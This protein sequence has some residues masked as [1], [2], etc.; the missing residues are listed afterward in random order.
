VLARARTYS[1][2]P[3]AE[4][5]APAVA[6]CAADSPAGSSPLLRRSE[7]RE[8]P[9]AYAMLPAWAMAGGRP[10]EPID[11]RLIDNA[12]WLLRTYRLRVTAAREAGHQTH[13]DGTALDLIPE[14]PVDQAAWDASAG[15]LARDL[16]WTPACA[17]SGVR[18]VCGLVPAV[19]FVG[20][21]GY[22]GHG[23]PRTCRPPKCLAH[24]HISWESPCY[25]TSAPSLPCEFVT[26][27]RDRDSRHGVERSRKG[28]R[29]FSRAP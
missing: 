20:Y 26:G 11:A 17:A 4:L 21:E 18:P 24:L 7:R 12:L 1:A 13:G 19:H 3:E 25:G 23:S 6:T 15:T 28:G 9:R 5:A 22:P 27:L 10:A 29:S 14:E 8:T 16:G 2:Q